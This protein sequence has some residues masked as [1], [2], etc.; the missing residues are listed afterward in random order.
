VRDSNERWRSMSAIKERRHFKKNLRWT[1]TMDLLFIF[2]L[3]DK[4]RL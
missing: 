1:T 4:Q 2:L 3:M